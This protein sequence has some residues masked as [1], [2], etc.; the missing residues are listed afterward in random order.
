[1]H[2]SANAR[3]TSVAIANL[4]GKFHANPF[5]RFCAKLKQTSK[6]R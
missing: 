5:G 4:P 2:T 1:M 6:Q 3:L